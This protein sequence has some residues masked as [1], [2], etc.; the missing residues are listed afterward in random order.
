MSNTTIMAQR[1]TKTGRFL[2]GNNGGGRKPGSRNK[3]SEAFVADVQATWEKHGAE[4]L[5]RVAREEPASYLRTIAALM[6][7]DV[8][9]D[10]SV[11]PV[12]FAQNFR[13]AVRLLHEMPGHVPRPMK[14]INGG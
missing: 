9:L 12:G 7:K 6:P 11:D 10:V 3:L 1:D 4:V 13:D 8:R 5:E 14:V 2:A